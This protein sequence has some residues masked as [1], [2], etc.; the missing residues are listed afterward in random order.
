M[1]GIQTFVTEEPSSQAYW[2]VKMVLTDPAASETCEECP[3]DLFWTSELY[4]E[5]GNFHFK[6]GNGCLWTPQGHLYNGHMTVASE[7]THY[8]QGCQ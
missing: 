3:G 1:P 2:T 4:Q 5:E 7:N 8:F 6:D